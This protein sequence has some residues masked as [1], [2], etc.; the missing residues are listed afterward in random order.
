MFI[1]P[2]NIF[3]YQGKELPR[4]DGGYMRPSLTLSGGGWNIFIEVSPKSGSH[5]D[6][7]MVPQHYRMDNV[8]VFTACRTLNEEAI[9]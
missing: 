7:F 6:R 3:D 5:G 9:I 2:S 4:K 8:D 1:T